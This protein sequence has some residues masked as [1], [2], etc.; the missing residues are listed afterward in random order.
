[1]KFTISYS[2]KIKAGKPYEMLEIF[3]AIE[4]DTAIEPMEVTFERAK[5]FVTDK[6]AEEQKRLSE[7]G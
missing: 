3:A 6:L 5:N 2:R 4:S 1:M 7:E